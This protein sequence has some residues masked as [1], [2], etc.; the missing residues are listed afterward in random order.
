MKFLANDTII[1]LVADISA[2]LER[3]QIRMEQTDSLKLRRINQIKSIHSSLAIEGNTLSESQVSAVIEGKRVVAPA[4]EILEVK[5]ALATYEL[6]QELD[7]YSVRDLLKA[8]GVMMNGIMPDAGR[9]RNCGEGVFKGNKCVHLA[10]PP[11]RV[12][13]LMKN[14]F[15]WLKSSKSHWLIRSCAFHYEFEFIH[16]FR[17]GNGRMG[18]LW[19][20]L[21]LS[22][23]N[24]IF[25]HLPVENLVYAN[26]NAYYNAINAS[27]AKGECSP[28]VEFMLEQILKSLK[29][30]QNTGGQKSGQKSGQ[31]KSTIEKVFDL[32]R[33]NPSITRK[34]LVQALSISPSAIQKHIAK[35]KTDGRMKR[36]GGDKGGHWE[37]KKMELRK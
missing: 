20:T 31:K 35:L 14:L 15:R 19:Q 5:N 29:L 21:I 33:K 7:A 27:S 12:P 13:F 28:F 11:D 36:I 37:V 8:H 25:E 24:P 6:Y 3:F 2:Q 26:Q 17:D 34:E 23:W 4:R 16:P 32:I 22:K 9:F 10:P 1:S 30:L 18:R